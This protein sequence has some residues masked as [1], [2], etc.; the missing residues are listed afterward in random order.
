MKT[1][2]SFEVYN[3]EEVLNLNKVFENKIPRMSRTSVLS[4]MFAVTRSGFRSPRHF[5]FTVRMPTVSAIT[6][7]MTSSSM[8]TATMTIP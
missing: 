2:K 8:T 4:T 3:L 5:R 1:I 6:M 7:T